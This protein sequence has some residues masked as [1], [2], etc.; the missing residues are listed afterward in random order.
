MGS[1][2]RRVENSARPLLARWNFQSV[3]CHVEYKEI[4]RTKR[5]VLFELFQLLQKLKNKIAATQF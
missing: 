2:E 3:A 1:S 5:L 4:L